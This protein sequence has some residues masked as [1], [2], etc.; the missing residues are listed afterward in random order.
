MLKRAY[1]AAL[2]LALAVSST[3]QAETLLGKADHVRDG[4]TIVVSRTPI[5]LQ[6]VAAPELNEKLGRASKDA[7]QR[8]V[9]G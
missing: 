1:L 7:M 4:D 3:L 5:R 6:G 9:A 8:I 2:L